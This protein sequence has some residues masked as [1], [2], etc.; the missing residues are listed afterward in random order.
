MDAGREWQLPGFVG[1]T[2]VAGAGAI[3]AVVA[4]AGHRGIGP[5][6]YVLLFLAIDSALNIW[7]LSMR[8][9]EQGQEMAMD[10]AVFVVMAFLLPPVGI[11][12]VITGAAVLSGFQRRLPLMKHLFNFGQKTCTCALG[13]AAMAVV[14]T[15][16]PLDPSIRSLVAAAIGAAV[17]FASSGIWVRGVV[18]IASGVQYRQVANESH[19]LSRLVACVGTSIGVLVAA[20]LEVHTAL[21]VV[22][23][24][25]VVAADRVLRQ[26]V[27]SQRDRHRLKGLL[28]TAADTHGSLG[29][30]EVET[31]LTRAAS[32]LLGGPAARLDRSKGEPNE[33]S[34]A[35][36]FQG[37]TR[38]LTVAARR[39]SYDT[40]DQLLLDGIAAIGATALENAR[41]LE[42]IQRE[43]LHDPLTGLG[44]RAL[45]EDRVQHTLA[46]VDRDGGT[47]AVLFIDLD[48][49]KRVNDSLGHAAGDALLREAATRIAS[50]LRGIDTA[51]RMG[52]DEFTVLLPDVTA[53]DAQQVVAR[54]TATMSAPYTTGGHEV[55]ARA[56]I[57]TAVFPT[58]GLDYPSLLTA[59]DQA[60]YDSK[61]RDRDLPVAHGHAS[62]SSLSM[63]SQ[64]HRAI[65]KGELRVVYQPQMDLQSRA[66]VGV[67]ALV[68]WNHPTLGQIAPVTFMGLAEA[69]GVIGDIDEWVIRA[70]CQQAGEWARVHFVPPRI[71][72]NLSAHLA[73]S[74]QLE[75]IVR[76]ALR[77]NNLDPCV[78][79][80]EVTERVA[81]VGETQMWESLSRLREL[82]T[83][84]A[85]DDFGTGYS[86]LSRLREFPVDNVKID[87]SF[88]SGIT[89][90]SD[91]APIVDGTI[92]LA[93]A[94]GATVT[95][96][97]IETPAQLRYL[98][99]RA[100]DIGQGYLIG[101]PQPSS[102]IERLL[103]RGA[104]P[105]VNL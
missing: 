61:R 38:W 23:A 71:A 64:L 25:P 34:S 101:R 65:G 89:A 67:E 46:R 88:V 79:E 30:S 21:I 19:A 102:G 3:A 72:V 76:D 54:L 32:D 11:L 35:L 48:R 28:R 68:R 8:W 56:H 78:L 26:F 31:A 87:R 55:F 69:S 13:V 94:I 37:R 29:V 84:I 82:G 57:G 80:L 20:A 47:F 99:A 74:P 50:A 22:A 36:Q 92:A 33:L 95:A 14:G 44:N 83:K 63:E 58:D 75:S 27:S 53:E 70:A 97:G 91:R 96:E 103:E 77:V 51:C 52:G 5:V 10:E 98:E 40:Q 73:R 49:F 17:F 43:A 9:R 90:A 105:A 100:C 39:D 81:S 7:P 18:A 1:A 42:E 62:A 66:I 12:S 16:L 45:F 60:M 86:G 59:A 4:V 85:V 104:L 15:K 6:G 2:A 41:L 93:R 24:V